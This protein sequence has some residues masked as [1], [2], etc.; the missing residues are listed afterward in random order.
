[1][2]ATWDGIETKLY[3]N[4]VLDG[5]DSVDWTG[6]ANTKALKIGQRG[7]NDDFF[8]GLIDEVEI[9]GRALSVSEI[10][11]IFDAG[12]S[13]NRSEPLTGMISHWQGE[14]NALDALRSLLPGPTAADES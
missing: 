6:S 13:G 8:D 10:Q 11:T 4:G 9:Y 2:A 5:T 1:M 7:L 3:V 14:E 12:N